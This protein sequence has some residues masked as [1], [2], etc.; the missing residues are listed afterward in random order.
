VL[1][2][3]G[4]EA[5][6]D[7]V[8]IDPPY[9]FDEWDQLLTKVDAETVVIESNRVIEM[10]PQWSTVR[11]KQYG[12]TVVLIARRVPGQAREVEIASG[13]GDDD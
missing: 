10:P 5:P 9:Q 6:F 3:L 4:R 11:E 2:H 8:L 7:L 12:G 13:N 1:V